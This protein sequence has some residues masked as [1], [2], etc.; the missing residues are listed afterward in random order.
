M[1]RASRNLSNARHAAEQAAPRPWTTQAAL[2][3]DWAPGAA[4]N[5]TGTLGELAASLFAG[6]GRREKTTH[7]LN[8]GGL[9]ERIGSEGGFTVGEDLRTDLMLLAL[10]QSIIRPRALVYP[11][12]EYRERIPVAE[13]GAHSSSAGALGG[14][15]FTWTEEQTNP[16]TGRRHRG[17]CRRPGG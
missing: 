13:E 5:G 6:N 15:Q 17:S 2:N 12:K 4:L 16:G 10:E 1:V 8:L 11:M 3:I 9:S 7:L 14:F